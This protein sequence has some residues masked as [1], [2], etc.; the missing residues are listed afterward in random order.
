[1]DV[2]CSSC[3]E[4]WDVYHLQHDAIYETNLGETEVAS[5]LQLPVNQRLLPHYREK[6]ALLGWQ[7][8]QSILNV[9]RCPF[10]PKDARANSETLAVKSAL[11]EILGDDED[12]LAST[13]ED[14]GL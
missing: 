12:G 11:E 3:G 9:I 7:F 10:C 6:F 5:W 13:F 8:G 4:P 2:H 14:Y 1:M